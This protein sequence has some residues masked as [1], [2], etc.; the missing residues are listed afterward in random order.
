MAKVLNRILD[1]SEFKLDLHYIHFRNNT[2]QKV[3]NPLISSSFALTCII[4]F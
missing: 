4:M 2:L 3:M 1:V